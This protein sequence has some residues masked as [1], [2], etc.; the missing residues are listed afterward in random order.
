MR[1][2]ESIH[3]A[4]NRKWKTMVLRNVKAAAETTGRVFAVSYNIAGKTLDCNALHDLKADW[5]RLVD[6][7]KITQ[8]DRYIHH[9]GRPVLR[10]YG[11]GFTTV[12]ASDCPVMMQ[13]LIRW[14]QG[15][16]DSGGNVAPTK[17][18]AYVVG[19]VPSH[20]NELSGDSRTPAVWKD[21]YE[22]LDAIH[23]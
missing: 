5:K 22:S 17:Y 21:V 13:N 1:F 19:G 11:I 7:E 15:Y 4:N 8:S 10:I 18:Q 23:P 20:W 14:F 3:L 16:P 12:P 6:E 2:M 9:N